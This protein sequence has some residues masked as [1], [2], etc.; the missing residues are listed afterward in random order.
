VIGEEL[1][2]DEQPEEVSELRPLTQEV[3]AER[4]WRQREADGEDDAEADARDGEGAP[5]PDGDADE[6]GRKSPKSSAVVAVMAW[7]RC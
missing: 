3:I 4:E 2:A 6:D 5:V 1:E 7:R